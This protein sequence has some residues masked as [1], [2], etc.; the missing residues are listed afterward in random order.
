MAPVCCASRLVHL[1]VAKNL[2]VELV[3]SYAMLVSLGFLGER[4]LMPKILAFVL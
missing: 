3:C 1:V 4:L 2:G